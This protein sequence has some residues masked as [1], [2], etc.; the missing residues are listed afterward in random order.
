MPTSNPRINVTLSP[1]RYAQMQRLSQLTGE[2]MSALVSSLLDTSGP[3]FD[4]TIRILEAA[5]D[6]KAQL[7]EG[8]RQD[9][10][11]AQAKIEKQLGLVLETYDTSTGDLLEQVERVARRA[12]GAGEPGKRGAARSTATGAKKAVSTPM[13]NRGVRSVGKTGKKPTRTRR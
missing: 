9:M 6:A 10:E 13:S 4:R 2:S 5:N 7:S 11:K 12:R 3:V 8:M 1:V